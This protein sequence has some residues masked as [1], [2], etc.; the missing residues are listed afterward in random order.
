VLVNDGPVDTQEPVAT[1]HPTPEP[2]PQADAAVEVDLDAAEPDP[3][4][5]RV[6]R[7]L[8]QVRE[9][10]DL[11]ARTFGGTVAR[12][13]GQLTAH[14]G[15]LGSIDEHLASVV[16]NL[17]NRDSVQDRTLADLRQRL[18]GLSDDV[19]TRLR[20]SEEQRV[21]SDRLVFQSSLRMLH[22]AVQR[23]ASVPST[24]QL[25]TGLTATLAA[26]LNAAMD[27]VVEDLSD[28]LGALRTELTAATHAD[29]VPALEGVTEAV[30]RLD[31]R[32]SEVGAGVTEKTTRSLE[33]LR[34]S[35]TD[36]A[37]NV[38]AVDGQI[39]RVVRDAVEAL[40]AE[41]A[42]QVGAVGT[43]VGAVG[44]QVGALG[45]QVS[46]ASDRLAAG[47]ALGPGQVS[48][49][50]DQ[51]D[52]R[53]EQMLRDAVA[54]LGSE[55]AAR[56]GL[57][58]EQVTEAR[59]A[60]VA[61]G[62]DLAARSGALG[63]QV[64]EARD[65]VTG[66]GSALEAQSGALGAQITEVGE[67]LS[68]VAASG[69]QSLERMQSLDGALA[70]L[71]A[72][73][74]AVRENLAGEV[75]RLLAREV[76]ERVGAMGLQLAK[77]VAERLD[78]LGL[79]VEGVGDRVLAGHGE[80]TARLGGVDQAMVAVRARI[81]EQSVELHHALEESVRSV[82]DIVAQVQQLRAATE[83]A[84][85]TLERH[86]GAVEEQTRQV[87]ADVDLTRDELLA[88]LAS[89]SDL[90]NAV[91]QAVTASRST[92]VAGIDER[93]AEVIGAIRTDVAQRLAA[94]E[95]LVGATNGGLVGVGGEVRGVAD[96]VAGLAELVR[97]G[98]DELRSVLDELEQALDA[99]RVDINGSFARMADSTT[100]LPEL[101]GQLRL[102]V[103]Q[104]AQVLLE[105]LSRS[106]EQVERGVQSIN[107]R[108]PEL[109][110][111]READARA[112]RLA[113]FVRAERERSHQVLVQVGE[114]VRGL[115]DQIVGRLE[116]LSS[117]GGGAGSEELRRLPAE[118]TALRVEIEQSL[119]QISGGL[120]EARR[121][122]SVT[123]Q[124][125]DEIG[126]RLAERLD[127]VEVLTGTVQSGLHGLATVPQVKGVLAAV[128]QQFSV[129][130]ALL[131]EIF[132]T[133]VSIE[134]GAV[135]SGDPLRQAALRRPGATAP[136][137]P[138][139]AS[140]SS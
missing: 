15:R 37:Q 115:G 9:G 64:T 70:E 3:S 76:D 75:G 54:A 77:A 6:E 23:L 88:R 59:D 93:T 27:P 83:A 119:T 71:G 86:A 4:M 7:Q 80:V 5:T 92:V 36:L 94:L 74:E 104:I 22:T 112:V 32:L 131:Q 69:D 66:L 48:Q 73:V 113:E 19:V 85:G 65:A 43:Q 44:T 133:V 97:H 41:L 137:G 42:S 38:G 2:E 128:E 62:S 116:A 96:R 30:G 14:D 135:R 79:H 24:E 109:D 105:Q 120:D 106:H 103:E 127:E 126:G 31:R 140:P 84:A 110:T 45:T 90:G 114:A 122:G 57:L 125:L 130:S 40:R 61:L 8:A 20:A 25:A 17:A 72:T 13:E 56:S 60:M 10:L 87:L 29:V 67:R 95:S 1:E 139:G 28:T 34:R 136:S 124:R 111:R 18:H 16:R 63:E 132:D 101:V 55:L 123:V 102:R 50:L 121:G 49:R 129:L 68:A 99:T 118:L 26:H 100:E 98:D 58:G 39:E 78:A 35:T 91:G 47:I 108:F 33:D 81:D 117:M 46:D 52:A 82:V 11:L 12:L 107:Q 89:L 51:A 138:D 134:S 53:V 21:D